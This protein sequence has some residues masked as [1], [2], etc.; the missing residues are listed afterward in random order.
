MIKQFGFQ[1]A[2]TEAMGLYYSMDVPVKAKGIFVIIHGMM[3]HSDRYSHIKEALIESD[4][5]YV[6]FD[7]PGHGNT[8]KYEA[9]TGNWIENGFD[10]CANE[11]G[12]LIKEFKK[13]YKIP[14]ILF[15]HSMGSF[16]STGIIGRYG[17]DLAG[18]ILSGTNDM[19]PGL[20]LISGKFIASLIIKFKDPQYKSKFLDNM[21]FGTYNKKIKSLRTEFDWLSTDENEVDKYLEDPLCGFLCSALLFKDLSSWLLEIYKKKNIDGIPEDLPIYIFSG[22]EDPVGNYGKGLSTFKNRLTNFGKKKITLKLY[23][24]KRHECLNETNKNEVVGHI[25]DFCSEVLKDRA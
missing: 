15:G 19:Q 11:I 18:C 9:E 6:A 8:I 12:E 2:T 21:A 24:G 3:E 16:L 23:K 5:G 7:L 22:E 10:S 25:M 14:I 20:L 4:I 1:E 17:N 13:I